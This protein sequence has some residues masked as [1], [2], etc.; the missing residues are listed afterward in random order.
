MRNSIFIY[1]IIFSSI[2]LG[3]ELTYNFQW[4]FINV[5]KLKLDLYQAKDFNNKLEFYSYVSTSGPLKLFRNYT[6]RSYGKNLNNKIW[7]FELIGKDRGQ[8]EHKQID[9][10]DSAPPEVNIFIDD[11]GVKPLELNTKQK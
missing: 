9:F 10:F 8:D 5:A 4:S 1:L 3:E 2:S 6:S 7:R 11:K